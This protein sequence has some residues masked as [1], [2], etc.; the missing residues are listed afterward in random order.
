[1]NLKI[2]YQLSKIN[3]TQRNYE[4]NYDRLLCFSFLSNICVIVLILILTEISIE[5]VLSQVNNTTNRKYITF[6]QL[7][8]YE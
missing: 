5:I 2:Q 4:A 7:F 3:E 8:Y 1:M 6:I